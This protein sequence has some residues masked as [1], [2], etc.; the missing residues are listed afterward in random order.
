MD[1]K[2]Q[3]FGGNINFTVWPTIEEITYVKTDER[4]FDPIILQDSILI[5]TFH[6]IFIKSGD[7][8][9]IFPGLKFYIPPGYLGLFKPNHELTVLMGDGLM[10]PDIDLEVRL[11]L[12][13]STDDRVIMPIGATVATLHIIPMSLPQRLVRVDDELVKALSTDSNPSSQ[14]RSQ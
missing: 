11:F 4:A 1:N 14:E 5:R 9:V 8:K 3:Y 12:M 2:P 6:D 7:W 13:N 10:F